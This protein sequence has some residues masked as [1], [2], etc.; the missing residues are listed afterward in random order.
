MTG[1]ERLRKG[2]SLFNQ[3]ARFMIREHQKLEWEYGKHLNEIEMEFIRNRDDSVSTANRA[4]KPIE[5]N[6]KEF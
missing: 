5:S 6:R 2:T 3:T 1:V 4:E